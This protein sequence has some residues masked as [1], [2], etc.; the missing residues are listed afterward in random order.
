M[1]KLLKKFYLFLTF[2]DKIKILELTFYSIVNSLLEFFSI[3][4]IIP[5]IYTLL[6]KNDKL[7]L[8]I[9]D[10]ILINAGLG[11]ANLQLYYIYIFLIFNVLKIFFI[12]FYNFRKFR[13]LVNFQSNIKNK[14]FKSYIW[15]PYSDLTKHKGSKII[16]NVNKSSMLSDNILKSII[17]IINDLFLIL[18]FVFAIIFF[19]RIEYLAYG[20][21]LLILV[22]LIGLFFKNKIK[23]IGDELNILINDYG[24]YL[25]ACIKNIKIIILKNK[26]KFFSDNAYEL[27]YKTSNNLALFNFFQSINRPIFEFIFILII[28]FV[29]IFSLKNYN[30]NEII[31]FLT[32]FVAAFSRIG[33]VMM[34][35]LSNHQALIF[36]KSQV[37][38]LLFDISKVKELKNKT[39]ENKSFKLSKNFTIKKLCFRYS[40]ENKYLFKDLNFNFN[41]GDIVKISGPTGAGKSTLGEILIGLNS[42]YEGD[43]LIDGVEL[44][45]IKD[46]WINNV[47]YIPQELYLFNDTI[48][49]NIFFGCKKDDVDIKKFY[50]LSDI[51]ELN[52]IIKSYKNKENTLVGE[53]GIRL[54]GGE[55]QRINIARGLVNE[56]EILLMDE[57]TNALNIEVEKKIFRN[58]IDM[59]KF[60]IIFVITHSNN[61]DE[62]FTK[63]VKIN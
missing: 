42:N 33:P 37:D 46:S 29:I 6:E 23:L 21:S 48:I 56:A 17:E 8:N 19:S 57:S 47:N 44:K 5:I 35:I 41:R 62:F 39:I 36:S 49:N 24:E 1:N 32:I 15:L 16:S 28:S 2:K 59:K 18:I 54:S 9:F 3:V 13:F 34:R 51:C 61:L 11:Q 52:K 7:S 26:Q 25:L 27:N 10:K 20:I 53:K 14:I 22:L 63:T 4:S 30:S 43:I 60:K 40:K 55:S 50:E 58:I 12:I 31:I 38:E 45:S